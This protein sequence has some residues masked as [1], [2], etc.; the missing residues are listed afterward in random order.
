[1]RPEGRRVLEDAGVQ[2]DGHVAFEA[3]LE[4]RVGDAEPGA[5][6]IE[7]AEGRAL[8]G[9]REAELD[10]AREIEL[11]VRAGAEEIAVGAGEGASRAGR[12]GDADA[13][14]R[15]EAGAKPDRGNSV[16]RRTRAR[17]L[18]H[19]AALDARADADVAV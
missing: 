2:A 13:A 17:R 7:D 3:A 16:C 19:L 12:G 6:G 11:R 4:A 5:G 8:R 9:H 15:A 10:A 14:Q 18:E 1:R